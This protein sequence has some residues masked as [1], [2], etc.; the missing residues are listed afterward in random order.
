MKIKKLDEG[1][2]AALYHRY[3]GQSEPQ[4]SFVEI[5][6]DEETIRADW[7][8]DIGGA[9]PFSVWHGRQRRYALPPYCLPGPVNELMEELLPFAEKMAAGYTCEWDG[10][11]HVGRLSED[12]R[13]AEGE[14]ER[15]LDAFAPDW[16][17][18]VWDAA[19]W[20]GEY[21]REHLDLWREKGADAV[22]AAIEADQGRDDGDG[23][24]YLESVDRY[25]DDLAGE[26]G[27]G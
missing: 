18:Q 8:G 15:E 21:R 16:Q 4:V 11:N 22:R 17:L 5:D 7:D 3:P 24:L 26:I 14:L 2:K 19:E 12:A 20:Y 13:E 6:L 23:P 1:D 25:L 9:V 10:S 27:E